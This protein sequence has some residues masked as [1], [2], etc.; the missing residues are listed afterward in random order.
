MNPILARVAALPKTHKVIT[1]WANGA[2]TRYD[3]HSAASAENY[4]VRMRRAIESGE[5]VSVEVTEI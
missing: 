4:A 3:A 2:E 5:A 1:V